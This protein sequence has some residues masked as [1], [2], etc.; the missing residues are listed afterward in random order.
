M[1]KIVATFLIALL[2]NAAF[3]AKSF[4]QTNDFKQNNSIGQL[5][6]PKIETTENEKADSAKRQFK[7]QLNKKIDS[8]ESAFDF[9]KAEKETMASYQKNKAADKKFSTQTKILIGA[10]IAAAV[11]G[12]VV[13]AASR[14]K[15]KTF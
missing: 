2:F 12:V 5:D 13:F 4:S 10:G 7:A 14:D 3:G 15:I 1:K 11:V 6:E 9:A 8:S